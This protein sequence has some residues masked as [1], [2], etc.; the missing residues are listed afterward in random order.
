LGREEKSSRWLRKNSISFPWGFHQVENWI[1]GTV[2]RSIK[3]ILAHGAISIVD[4]VDRQ[5]STPALFGL[6]IST[7]LEG[8]AP[9]FLRHAYKRFRKAN[10]VR[11]S[12]LNINANIQI[13]PSS[14]MFS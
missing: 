8:A 13:L 7:G 6:G 14:P 1:R 10:N 4:F 12:F 9:I 11:A 2:E 3:V 5:N